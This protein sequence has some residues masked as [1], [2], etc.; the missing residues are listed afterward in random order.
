MTD[1]SSRTATG[2]IRPLWNRVEFGA[3]AADAPWPDV[4]PHQALERD[5]G[6]RLPTM[7]WF[8]SMGTPWP[9]EQATVAAATCHDLMVCLEPRLADGR[10][11]PFTEI[12]AGDWDEQLDE[13]VTHASGHPGTVVIR[14]AHEPN[15]DRLPWSLDHPTPCARDPEQWVATWRHV[16]QRRPGGE[17]EGR[18]TWMW[19]VDR[20]DS[21]VPVEAYWP[22]ADVVDVLGIDAYNGFE[23][24]TPAT[25]LVG[26]MYDRITALHPTADLW[27]AEIGCRAVG[28]D[29]PHDKAA[30]FADLLSSEAFPRLTRMCFFHADKERDW[31][32]TAP[33]VARTIAGFV[34]RDTA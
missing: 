15:L 16:A 19:C 18:I 6:V 32:I 2:V 33:D 7:S 26:P 4:G 25:D 8:L 34:R 22:G 30:W 24:W 14:F 13:L 5:L 1:A 11:V 31:R 10:P 27:L 9:A 17:Q 3:Y 12:L 23:P 28:A 20:A 21:G 29:E